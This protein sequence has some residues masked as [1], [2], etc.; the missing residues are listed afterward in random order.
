MKNNRKN[1]QLSD[2]KS[3]FS[4]KNINRTHCETL[5]VLCRFMI[6]FLILRPFLQQQLRHPFRQLRRD[7]IPLREHAG[8]IHTHQSSRQL[9]GSGGHIAVPLRC[10]RQH[11]LRTRRKRGQ[12]Q[13]HHHHHRHRNRQNPKNLGIPYSLFPKLNSHFHALAIISS[14][15]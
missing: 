11:E 7:D 14:T 6:I 4:K 10:L 3:L 2:T 9:R 1:N 12:L 5:I 15:L 8:Q 13:P